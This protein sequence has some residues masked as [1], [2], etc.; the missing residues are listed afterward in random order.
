MIS[1]VP[2]ALNHTRPVYISWWNHV[3][4]HI[5]PGSDHFFMTFLGGTM[6]SKLRSNHLQALQQALAK[7]IALNIYPKEKTLPPQ[8]NK[9]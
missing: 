4:T 1:G 6:P 7:K 3:L 9:T 2:L 5:F 8:E